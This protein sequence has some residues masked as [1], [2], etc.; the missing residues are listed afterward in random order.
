MLTLSPAAILE[1]NKVSSTGV[2]LILLEIIVSPAITVRIVHNNENIDWGGHTWVAF[3][4]QLGEISEDGKEIPRLTLK[5]SNISGILQQYLEQTNG[6]TDSTVI[7]RVVHSGHLDLGTAEIE[8]TFAVQMV[9]T[10]AYWATFTLGG[11]FT[12]MRRLPLRRY[13]KDFCPYA[14]KDAECGYNGPETACSKT[15][16]RCRELNNAARF[17]GEPALPGGIY[18]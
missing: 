9:T 1:K 7:L 2:W 16:V 18:V 17:G 8:E 14:F 4:F 12:L 5:V 11:D 15:L 13:L 6:G 3:P 10:D